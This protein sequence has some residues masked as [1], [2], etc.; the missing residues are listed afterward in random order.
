MSIR[1]IERSFSVLE[2][3]SIEASTDRIDGRDYDT[4]IVI[5]G[6]FVIGGPRLEKFIEDFRSLVEEYYI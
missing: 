2:D 6:Q 1:T 3:L 5:K 4:K